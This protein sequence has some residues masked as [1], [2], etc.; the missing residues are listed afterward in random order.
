M[1]IYLGTKGSYKSYHA[2]CEGV[3]HIKASRKGSVVANFPV[4]WSKREHRNGQADRWH[5][6]EDGEFTPDNLIR[7][8]LQNRWFGHEGRCKLII[9]EAG[10]YYNARDWA[11]D[12]KYRKSWI[13]FFALSRKLGY[14]EILIAQDV[15]MIDRQIR[16]LA[17][18]TVKHVKM[19]T[20]FWFKLLPWPIFASV[21]HWTGAS[22]KNQVR[23]T[24]YKPWMGK[25]YNTFRM[26]DQSVFDG[27]EGYEEFW[28]TKPEIPV[29]E[30]EP[31]NADAPPD[32]S[33][34]EDEHVESVEVIDQGE[35]SDVLSAAS[36]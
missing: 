5:Y 17:D 14:E 23:F 25:R 29:I 21:R 2:L 31:S 34:V 15:R 13:N 6:L 4:K 30:V 18:F 19:R 11:V 12:P 10:L 8:S 7:L 9:D 26:F 33:V 24:P 35:A 36:S 28:T 27:L 3:K 16:S 32:S 20:Y 22:F 1:D